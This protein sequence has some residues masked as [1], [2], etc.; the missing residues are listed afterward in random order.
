MLD[1]LQPVSTVAQP[2]PPGPPREPLGESAW[3][4]LH[5]SAFRAIW[6]ASVVSNV[7]TWMQN[8][9]VAWLMT[10]LTPSPVLVAL[11]QT[12]TTLPVF[13]IGLPAG[14][15]ADLID[16]RRLLL[17]SQTWMLIAA[18]ALGI[19]TLANLTTPLALLALTF[20]LGL[21]GAVNSPAWQAIVPELVPRRKLATAVALNGAG[22]NLARAV[23][24][25]LGG[26]LVAAAGPGAVFILNAASFLATIVVLFR[27][28]RAPR[29]PSDQPAERLIGATLAGLRYVRFSPAL[30][31]LLARSAIFVVCASAL[32][33]LLPVVARQR[34]GLDSSGYGALLACLGLGAVAGAFGLPRMRV[35]VKLD[36]LV[37]A[38]TIVFG[39]TTIALGWLTVLPVLLVALALAG[40]AWLM[41]MSSFNVAAQTVAP[42]WVSARVLSAY[43]LVSQGGLALGSLAWGAVADQFGLPTA[44]GLAGVGLCLGIVA[45]PLWRLE[46]KRIDLRPS[47]PL[48]EVPGTDQIDPERGP[49]LI[50]VEYRVARDNTREF[51]AAMQDVRIVRR[52][53]GAVRWR[54][55]QDPLDAERFVETFVVSSWAEHMRQ[56]ERGTMADHEIKERARHLSRGTPLV[57]HLIAAEP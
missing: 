4:P 32:W 40:L 35:L 24:P 14:A 11:I 6:I 36:M 26:L 9:G 30:R 21:G 56:H 42:A 44:L 2:A 19:L 41:I 13:L 17:I 20:A 47:V 43:L 55:Y 52:R 54:L 48:A 51:I 15:L 3:G 57:S 1:T 34:L 28:R 10:T 16:R 50:T 22:F 39:L 33:A 23:G 7:G 18:A 12:A 27:W 29:P 46:R 25:A 45:A 5:E 53:D 49:V 8:V 37:A 31:A 38:A